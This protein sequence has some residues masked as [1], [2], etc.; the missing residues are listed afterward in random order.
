M[1]M[2][3]LGVPPFQE[4]SRCCKKLEAE[5]R[6]AACTSKMVVI[7]RS[8]FGRF[9]CLEDI[10]GCA[11]F[12][13]IATSQANISSCSFRSCHDLAEITSDS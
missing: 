6:E 4:A 12:G 1:K 2:D 13:P 8:K 3:D 11:F 9:C 10:L 7:G 5:R